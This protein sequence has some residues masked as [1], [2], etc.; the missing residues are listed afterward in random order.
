[1]SLAGNR[2]RIDALTRGILREWQ[3]SREHWRDTRSDEFNA[4][5]MEELA[6][7]AAAASSALDQLETLVQQIKHD[8]E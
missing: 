8:C 4:R 1:M 5:Y 3:N 2:A 6:S 7:A